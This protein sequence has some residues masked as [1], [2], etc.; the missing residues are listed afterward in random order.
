MFSWQ[1]RLFRK[2]K[3]I[4]PYLLTE[5]DQGGILRW[6]VNPDKPYYFILN[7]NLYRK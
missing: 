4:F 5:K 6:K 7:S 2:V 1:N 3:F